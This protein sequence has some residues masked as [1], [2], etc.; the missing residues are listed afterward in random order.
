VHSVLGDDVPQT[1]LDKPEQAKQL[2]NQAQDDIEKISGSF[3][4]RMETLLAEAAALLGVEST[5]ES[6]GESQNNG[7]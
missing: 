6:R 4:E 3:R 7:S 2:Y 1:S 5:N